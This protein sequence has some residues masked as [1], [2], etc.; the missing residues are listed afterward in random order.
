MERVAPR[1]RPCAPPYLK[2]R[3]CPCWNCVRPARPTSIWGWP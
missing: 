2:G 1:P 3:P